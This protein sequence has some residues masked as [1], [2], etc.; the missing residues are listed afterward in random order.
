MVKRH[1][2]IVSIPLR[3]KFDKTIKE[4]EKA[5]AA[6][7]ERNLS[8]QIRDLRIVIDLKLGITKQIVKNTKFFGAVLQQTHSMSQVLDAT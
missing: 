7:S 5:P 4:Q 1:Q 8:G 6:Q 2:F 3:G